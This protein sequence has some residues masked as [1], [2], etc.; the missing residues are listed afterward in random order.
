MQCANGSASQTSWTDQLD[1]PADRPAG[2]TSYFYLKPWPVRIFAYFPFSLYIVAA[3]ES[4]K[5]LVFE[6]LA[7][8]AKI[9]FEIY[10]FFGQFKPRHSYKQGPCKERA[11]AVINLTSL[12]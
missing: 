10:L 8:W 4:D 11:Y 1:S 5:G 2:Q 12:D 7:T 3:S 6:K 9:A